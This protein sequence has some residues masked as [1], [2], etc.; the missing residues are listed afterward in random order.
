MR[1]TKSGDC[2]EMLCAAI[3]YQAALDYRD[4]MKRADRVRVKKLEDES[5]RPRLIARADAEIETLRRF[6]LG[7][8][9]DTLSH[10]MGEYIMSEVERLY[11]DGDQRWNKGSARFADLF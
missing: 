8:W 1:H 4:A 6:F 10:G 11:R 5:E 9:G 2:Y 7:E 3:L